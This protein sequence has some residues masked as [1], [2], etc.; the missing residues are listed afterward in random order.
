MTDRE[1]ILIRRDVANIVATIVR[2]ANEAGETTL[3]Y[4]A[5]REW[6]AASQKLSNYD[7][8]AAQQRGADVR[9]EQS[10]VSSRA[11]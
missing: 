4:A 1:R 5:N 11:T 3:E 9:T 10:E 6:H 7:R 8:R 2:S